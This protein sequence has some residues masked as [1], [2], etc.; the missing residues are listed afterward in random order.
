MMSDDNVANGII[1]A[2]L[3]L[4]VAAGAIWLVGWQIGFW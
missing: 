4:A 1:K 3:L 2:V